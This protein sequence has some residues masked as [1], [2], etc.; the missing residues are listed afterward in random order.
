MRR[1]FLMLVCAVMAG[2]LMAQVEVTSGLSIDTVIHEPSTSDVGVVI[3]AMREPHP[4]AGLP[5]YPDETNVY[6]NGRGLHHLPDITDHLY[7]LAGTTT[8]DLVELTNRTGAT[9]RIVF[10]SLQIA[11]RRAVIGEDAVG[12][13]NFPDQTATP[14]L[15][16]VDNNVLDIPNGTTAA[17]WLVRT[18]WAAR[19]DTSPRDYV[20][21]FQFLDDI[22][23]ED[24]FVNVNLRVPAVDDRETGCVASENRAPLGLALLGMGAMAAYINRRR[25]FARA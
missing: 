20:V 1:I 23:G 12:E 5:G 9:I 2:G 13:A 22:S 16:G 17:A 21:T 11:D 15:I 8:H 3:A 25:L 24:K 19:L 14:E 4:N 6:G 7:A 10:S 18:R